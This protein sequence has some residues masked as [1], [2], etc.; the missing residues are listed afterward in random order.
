MMKRF[1][2]RY[3]VNFYGNFILED[4][5]QEWVRTCCLG[6]LGWLGLSGELPSDLFQLVIEYC[7]LGSVEDMMKVTAPTLEEAEIAFCMR[8]LLKVRGNRECLRWLSLRFH[9]PGAV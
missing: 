2:N 8:S 4:R 3:T 1:N 5:A 9:S 7:A 6:A